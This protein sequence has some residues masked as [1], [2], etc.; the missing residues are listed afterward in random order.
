[1]E[2]KRAVILD[3]TRV[4]SED[5]RILS[6]IETTLAES[7][8]EPT[9]FSLRRMKIA[10]CIGCFGCWLETPG[11]CREND[12]GRE[13]VRAVAASDTVVLVT[14]V[15]YGGYSSELKKAL[16]RWVPLELPYFQERCGEIHHQP[17]YSRHPRLVVI[18][19]QSEPN[20]EEARLF[21]IIAGRNALNLHTSH[22]A[23]IVNPDDD[24]AQLRT[25]IR[26]LLTRNDPV[27]YGPQLNALIGHPESMPLPENER[28]RALVIVGSPKTLSPSS[29]AVFGGF[30][31]ELLMQRGWEVETLKLNA[32]LKRRA[33]QSEFLSAVDRADLL[34]LAF[35]LY[36]DS[37][38][39]LV[40]KALEL[41]D[42]HR[43]VAE[44][45]RPQ[46][47]LAISNNGFI[48]PH[49]NATALAIC[50]NFALRSG[51]TWAG[52]LAIGAGEALSSGAPLTGSGR[53]GRPPVNHVIK[54]LTLTADALAKGLPVPNQAVA[55]AARDPIPFIPNRLWRWIYV[56][57][58]TRSWQKRAASNGV[59]IE[60][61][62]A[63]PYEVTQT[64]RLE[65]GT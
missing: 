51:I 47:L 37:L 56:K 20:Q 14:P 60:A 11:I 32:G 3:G 16:E 5:S 29:S 41:I 64:V 45:R 27:T 44:C 40:T 8:F 28:H 43:S 54:A 34:V 65:A 31:G 19:L 15:T 21:K 62:L 42:A 36:V 53:S 50:R 12:A 30:I 18:G 7:G 13:V 57:G 38:P 26:D 63:K 48:E 17:R 6:M 55:L 46:R 25:I 23:E 49:Q 22:A 24:P 2:T 35:P 33:W 10:H 52:G 4:E 39:H 9:T 59:S 58:G 1:M 61:I